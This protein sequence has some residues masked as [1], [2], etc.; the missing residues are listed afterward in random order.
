MQNAEAMVRWDYPHGALVPLEIFEEAQ[1][2]LEK[3]A[4]FNC[5]LRGPVYYLSNVLFYEDGSKFSG[6]RAHG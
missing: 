5:R 1:V 3:N 2:V 4:K 6:A